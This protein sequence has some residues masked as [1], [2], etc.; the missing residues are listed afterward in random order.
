MSH[1]TIDTQYIL[2]APVQRLLLFPPS[3][4]T[5]IVACSPSTYLALAS[6]LGALGIKLLTRHRAHSSPWMP[7]TPA[8]IGTRRFRHEAVSFQLLALER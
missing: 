6:H 2:V 3:I 1:P 8:I 5:N 7:V 4:V